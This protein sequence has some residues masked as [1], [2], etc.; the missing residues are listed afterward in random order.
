LNEHRFVNLVD[1][2]TAIEV[3]RVDYNARRPHSSLAHLTPNEY[4]T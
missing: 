3:W 1:A 2:K 4:V